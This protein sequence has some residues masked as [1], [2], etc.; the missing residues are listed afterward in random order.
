LWKDGVDAGTPRVPDDGEQFAADPVPRTSRNATATDLERLRVRRRK[1]SRDE[2]RR[3]Q[4][5]R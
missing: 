2:G 3:R 1:G 4:L 5:C